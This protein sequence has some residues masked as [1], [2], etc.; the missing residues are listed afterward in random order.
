MGSRPQLLWLKTKPNKNANSPAA[1][2][3]THLTPIETSATL[4]RPPSGPEARQ[5][6]ASETPPAA[7][8]PQAWGTAGRPLNC[9][10]SGSHPTGHNRP[11][12]PRLLGLPVPF[13]H[14]A[15]LG[16]GRGLSARCPLLKS[17]TITAFTCKASR[18]T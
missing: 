14:N 3:S 5:P 6:P 13:R 11:H 2:L 16:V 18:R 8:A 4:P 12:S 9:L 1:D 17:Q 10:P 7:L 15:M